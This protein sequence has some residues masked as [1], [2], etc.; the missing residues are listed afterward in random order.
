MRT[1][2]STLQNGIFLSWV[3]SGGIFHEAARSEPSH[4]CNAGSRAR[5]GDLE[6]PESGTIF[7]QT[8]ARKRATRV[9]SHGATVTFKRRGHGEPG[10]DPAERCAGARE[11][12]GVAAGGKGHG[13]AGDPG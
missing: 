5:T 1:S 12:A 9:N 11:G 6:V 2:F 4:A 10:A 7:G 8:V 13:A 3:F